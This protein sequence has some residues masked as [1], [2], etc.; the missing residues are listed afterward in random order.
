MAF[1]RDVRIASK[2][3]PDLRHL[4]LGDPDALPRHVEVVAGGI[5]L[6]AGDG[7]ARDQPGLPLELRVGEGQ[8]GPGERQLLLL[9]PVARLQAR[10]LA[11]HAG[12]PRLCLGERDPIGPVVD[13]EQDVARGRPRWFSRTA[14]SA[15]SPE[16]SAAIITLSA[17][18]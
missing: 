6:G 10:D 3:C 13:A 15:I 5:E 7:V 14:T 18:T 8:V 16:T 11:A 4:L 17:W 2:L 12:E 1:H 9:L